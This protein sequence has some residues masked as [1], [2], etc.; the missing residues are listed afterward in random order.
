MHESGICGVIVNIPCKH[1]SDCGVN[2]GGCCAINVF[3]KG[4]VSFGMCLKSCD[5]YTGPARGRGDVLHKLAKTATLGLVKPCNGCKK[6]RV[7]GNLKHPSRQTQEILA[8]VD[9]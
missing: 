3:G 7:N 4:T 2:G 6:R 9:T 8:E 5:Q 1:W